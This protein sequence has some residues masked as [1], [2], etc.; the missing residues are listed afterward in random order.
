MPERQQIGGRAILRDLWMHLRLRHATGADAS[1]YN[2]LQKL[3][4][5]VVLFV[6]IPLMILTGMTMS[7]SATAAYPWLI[8]LFQG[9]Q[10]ARSL[11]F[12][13][14]MALLLFFIIH[15]LQLFVVGF[16]REMRAILTGYYIVSS[17]KSP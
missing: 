7:H 9:R 4:Y 5:L 11:H 1:R 2:L 17:E 15:F 10:T 8:D 14:A 3:S 12:V 6:L 13:A 16:A